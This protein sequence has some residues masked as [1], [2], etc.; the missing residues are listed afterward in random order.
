MC[1]K[2]S[3]PHGAEEEVMTWAGQQRISYSLQ[4][5]LTKPNVKNKFL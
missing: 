4:K 3:Q 5:R 1:A 2:F